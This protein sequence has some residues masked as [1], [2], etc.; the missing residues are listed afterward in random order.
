MFLI[1]LDDATRFYS[2]QDLWMDFKSRA[3]ATF[4]M[5]EK[6]H[7]RCPVRLVVAKL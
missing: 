3:S 5:G 4:A 1:L 2:V 7:L 6:G